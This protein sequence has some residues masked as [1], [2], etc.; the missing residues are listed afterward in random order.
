MTAIAPVWRRI[1]G[2]EL[3]RYRQDLGYS[4]EDAARILECDRSK[5]SRVET[6]QRG[7]RSR[8]LR[9]LLTEYGVD[10]QAQETL[11]GIANPHGIRG[12]R[13]SNVHNL[14]E[15][16]VDM[17]ALETT[18]PHIRIYE[19]QQI[20]DLL[21][22]EEYVYAL[23]DACADL[24]PDS[25]QKLLTSSCLDRQDI[26][27]GE[28]RP[29]ITVVIGEAALRHMPGGPEVTRAQ[30]AA[31][32]LADSRFPGVH[33]QVL[34]PEKGG[35]VA[36]GMGSFAIL[37]YTQVLNLGIVYLRGILSGIFVEDQREIEAY[38]LAFR[39]LAASALTPE[40]SAALIEQIQHENEQ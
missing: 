19:A 40:A 3:R 24:T 32:A 12:W 37:R 17:I 15:S 23:A 6:G 21:Q 30:L 33:I 38:E 28:L 39:Q 34:L 2:A 1:V 29:D 7:I 26:V 18:A 25:L 31:L 10:K 35:H 9:D 14:P 4:L 5:I 27:F 11:A 20:P 16:Y 22:S 8:E 13:K 36:R